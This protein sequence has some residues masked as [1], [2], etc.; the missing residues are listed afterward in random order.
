LIA[1]LGLGCAAVL[2]CAAVPLEWR[3]VYAIAAYT[4]LR[5]GELRVLAWGDID[6]DAK[7][8]RVTKAWDYE[9]ETTKLPKTAN[10]VRRVPIDASL[11]PLLTRMQKGNAP[12]ATVLPLLAKSEAITSAK[13]RATVDHL[14]VL[15][16]DHLNVANVKRAELHT[17]TSTHV[18]ANF[19]SWR[20]SGL[21]WLALAGVGVDKIMLRLDR[22][23]RKQRWA[24]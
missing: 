11:V 23:R 10:G 2:S 14:A 13:R 15:F 12:D 22:T 8:L 3:E 9:N 1:R 4:Y 20:D 7:L 16:R 18:Q 19:R 21:T 24:T 17:T 6:L 5:P